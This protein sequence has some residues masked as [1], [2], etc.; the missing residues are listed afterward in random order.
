M[1]ELVERNGEPE[2]LILP[3]DAAMAQQGDDGWLQWHV[4]ECVPIPGWLYALLCLCWPL[5][6]RLYVRS[7]DGHVTDWPACLAKHGGK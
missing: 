1:I 6:R 2:A 3:F 5:L 7:L 4:G